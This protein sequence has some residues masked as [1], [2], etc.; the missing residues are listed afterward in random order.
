MGSTQITE[1]QRYWL[2]HVLA[3][4]SHDGS[5]VAYAAANGLKPR[6]LYQWRTALAKR[7]FLTARKAKPLSEFAEVKVSAKPVSAPSSRS[8]SVHCRLILPCGSI[9]EYF[10]PIDPG[11]LSQLLAGLR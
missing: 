10:D 4:A 9:V 6:D 11:A 2:D 5:I 7:G 8:A 3:A 1:R